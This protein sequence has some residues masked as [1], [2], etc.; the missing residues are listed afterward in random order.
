MKKYTP[1][2]IL[3]LAFFAL[4]CSC[5]SLSGMTGTEAPS[6]SSLK[7]KNANS[8]K[9]QDANSFPYATDDSSGNAEPTQEI[10][11]TPSG[12]VNGKV[13]ELVKNGKL[14]VM[15]HG[16]A[17]VA[18]DLQTPEAGKALIIVDFSLVYTGSKSFTFS[19]SNFSIKDSDSRVYQESFSG[20]LNGT[21]SYATLFSGERLHTSIQFELPNTSTGLV[22]VF[23][24]L[25]Y[26]GFAKMFV[27][28][29]EKPGVLNA[30]E[31]MAGEIVPAYQSSAS[32]RTCGK[33]KIQL[34]DQNFPTIESYLLDM[35]P[36]GWKLL[37]LDLSVENGYTGTHNLNSYS[38]M[39]MQ[40][41]TGR[42]YGEGM[43]GRSAVQENYL[44][45]EEIAAGEKVRGWKG[46][47]IP[48]K[49]TVAFVFWCGG[50][51]YPY[52]ND[53]VYI[54]TPQ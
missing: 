4:S 20:R 35:M 21:V 46:F 36:A 18:A 16:W 40:D 14:N 17:P 7:T 27:P 1:V 8:A 34:H 25:S 41:A 43:L 47:T 50:E 23:E 38:S 24:G 9:T 13:G 51:S 12:P 32:A 22:F 44:S 37:A 31:K 28:L 52:S 11:D 5:E 29:A 6:S 10:I 54:N 26:D 39:W 2:V 19:A 33:W 42:R 3:L 53:K 48:E 45:S 15:V 49:G 30:P